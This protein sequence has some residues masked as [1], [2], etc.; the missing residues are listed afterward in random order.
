MKNLQKYYE[1]L[2][3]DNFNARLMVDMPRCM[4]VW[5]ACFLLAKTFFL[6]K[7]AQLENPT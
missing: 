3:L 2:L 5:K 6:F 1:N 4:P 7:C